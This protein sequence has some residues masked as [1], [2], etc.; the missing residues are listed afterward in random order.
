MALGIFGNG[1]ERGRGDRNDRGGREATRAASSISLRMVVAMSGITAIGLVMLV[2]GVILGSRHE[3][4][5]H[6]IDPNTVNTA[7]SIMQGTWVIDIKKA[8]L[9]I[10]VFGVCIILATGVVGWYFSRREIAPIQEAMR[11]QRN[12]VA[13]ASHELKTPLAVIGARTELLEHRLKAG[14][15]LEPVIDD[16][17]DDVTRMNDVINDLLLAATSALENVPTDVGK[18]VEDA[19]DSIRLLADSHGVTLDVMLPGGGSG[20]DAPVIVSG[21]ETGIRRC[22]VAVLDNA[23]AHSP[24]GSSVE[25]RVAAEHGQAVVTIRDHGPGLGDDPERLFHRFSRAG[26]GSDHQ[27]YGLGLA[28]ARDIAVRYGGWIEAAPTAGEGTTM[29]L[30]IPLAH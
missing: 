24:A 12:F 25:V 18:A 26:G 22:V 3:F 13:D 30:T 11:L 23:I 27:G 28:L 29:R 10:G 8:I 4:S 16:L 20:H 19:V 14:R 2:V 7:A 9:F 21:G 5:E 15:P 1:G 6:G 17:K